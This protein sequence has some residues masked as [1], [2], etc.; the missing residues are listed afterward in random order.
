M[1]KT[2]LS[3]LAAAAVVGLSTASMAQ[4]NGTGTSASPPQNQGNVPDYGR[5]GNNT[6]PPAG[7]PDT[8]KPGSD[9][10]SSQPNSTNPDA[11]N[12]NPS[13]AHRHRMRHPRTSPSN[14]TP[15]SGSTTTPDQNPH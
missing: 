12:G 9:D 1:M 11:M 8:M 13:K 6:L 5:S 4:D 2:K 7:A 14:P 10:T 3:I 15:D